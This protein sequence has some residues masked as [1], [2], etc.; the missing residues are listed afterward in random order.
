MACGPPQLPKPR[1]HTELI[2]FSTGGS[3]VTRRHRVEWSILTFPVRCK[4]LG[5]GVDTSHP[6]GL[7]ADVGFHQGVLLEQVFHAEQVFAIVLR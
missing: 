1:C 4:L 5:R 2:C 3:W 7:D 6:L